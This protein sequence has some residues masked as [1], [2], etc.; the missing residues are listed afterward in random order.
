MRVT[1]LRERPGERVEVE[2]DGR[3]WRTFPAAVVVR[4]GLLPGVE[5]D[6]ERLRTVVRELRRAEAVDAA[7][8][9]VRRR[10]VT[11]RGLEARLARRG[12]DARARAEAVAAVTRA[13]VVDDERYAV[14]RAQALADRGRGDEAIRWQLERDGVGEHA[15][16]RALAR[17]EAEHTRAAKVVASRGAGAKTARYLA[18]RGFSAESVDAALGADGTAAL[19]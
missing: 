14:R 4:A 2:A 11:E 10:E 17:L 1:G 13:G 9:I 7:A 15:V 16:E 12:I 5:L 3:A 8:R 6:R 18:A 19:G